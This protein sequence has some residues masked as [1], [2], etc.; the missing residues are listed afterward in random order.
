MSDEIKQITALVGHQQV[1]EKRG[2]TVHQALVSVA[3]RQVESDL[4]QAGRGRSA[5]TRC[6]CP[7]SDSQHRS[8]VGIYPTPRNVALYMEI[9]QL[10]RVD[11]HLRYG[12][13]CGLLTM[14]T[15]R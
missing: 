14:A 9:R 11:Y 10:S 7:E 5:E 2:W 13:L 15:N 3:L 6:Q 4:K 8:G 12:L 1:Q